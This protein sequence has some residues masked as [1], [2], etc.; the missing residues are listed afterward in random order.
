MSLV[1]AWDTFDVYLFDVDGTLIHC[2]DAVH[3]YAFCNA[4]TTVARFPMNLDGVVTHGNT[5]VGILR[6]AFALAGIPEDHW[7]PQLLQIRERMCQEV[8][9]NKSRLCAE[10]LPGVREVLL[11]LTGKGATLGV[12]TGNLE[13]IGREKLAAAGLLDFFDFGAWSDPFESRVDVFRHA[14]QQIRSSTRPNA[15]VLV[16]GDTPADVLAA[17]AHHLPVISVATGIYTFEQLAASKPS[18]CL[19]TLTELL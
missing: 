17:R 1:R 13:R 7:R 12:A 9:R 19:H 10:V 16:L 6:D 8:E 11:H 2:T 14:I 5:D 15:E 18:L 4:L 3:Y